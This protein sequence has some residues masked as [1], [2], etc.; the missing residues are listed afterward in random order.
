SV[1]TEDLRRLTV[2]NHQSHGD[3][4]LG[5]REICDFFLDAVNKDR[6]VVFLEIERR[7]AGGFVV[8]DRID[9]DQVSGNADLLGFLWFAQDV[10][11]QWLLL[12]LLS[13]LAT[14]GWALVLL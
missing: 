2:F 5:S 4:R 12:L 8:D 11:R 1:V 14:L 6:E 13:L 10:G 9:V 7:L 3:R